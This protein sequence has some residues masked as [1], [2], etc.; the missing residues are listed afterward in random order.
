MLLI[1]SPFYREVLVLQPHRMDQEGPET[2]Q[3]E[4]STLAKVASS[5][6]YCGL[7]CV[8]VSGQM[9]WFHLCIYNIIEQKTYRLSSLSIISFVTW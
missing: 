5:V 2:E 6:T 1:N 9:L 4:D 7:V 8:R 3:I